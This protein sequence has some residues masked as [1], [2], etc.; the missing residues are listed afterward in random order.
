LEAFV[1]QLG[2]QR[3]KLSPPRPHRPDIWHVDAFDWLLDL[4]KEMYPPPEG[5]DAKH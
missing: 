2:V 5:I 4:L 1:T 3:I